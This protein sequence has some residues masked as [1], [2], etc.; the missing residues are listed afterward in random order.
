VPVTRRT[1]LVVPVLAVA[2]CALTACGANAPSSPRRTDAQAGATPM[3]GT[4]QPASTPA[5]VRGMADH[6]VLPGDQD[7]IRSALFKGL[8]PGKV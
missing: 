6:G 5:G 7:V 8:L 1:R 3:D 4:V 2:C